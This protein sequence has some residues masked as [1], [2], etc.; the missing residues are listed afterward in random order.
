MSAPR[1]ARP[2]SRSSAITPPTRSVPAH[3]F[4][5]RN[6][7]AYALVF[8]LGAAM[9]A[10]H[11]PGADATARVT[12]LAGAGGCAWEAGRWLHNRARRRA[13]GLR[14]LAD[15]QARARLKTARAERKTEQQDVQQRD[16]QA[17]RQTLQAQ[18]QGRQVIQ[19]A[20]SE[21]EAE[22]R[23]R[24]A[25]RFEA[26]RA[27]A[28]RL[29][30]LP[31]DVWIV[32]LTAIFAGRGLRLQTADIPPPSNASSPSPDNASEDGYYLRFVHVDIEVDTKVD[33]EME[34]MCVARSLPA[35]RAG[36][37]ADVESLEQWRQQT[38]AQ[39]AYLISRDGFSTAVVRLAPRLPLTLVEP[40][41]L[42]QW[43]LTD[44]RS[45]PPAH[46]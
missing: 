34:S 44:A 36:V 16:R 19:Q 31:E 14:E 25:A 5:V 23:A 28:E 21:R 18:K 12:M 4:P 35:G 26:V 7:G 15:A 41:L 10:G 11:R 24:R 9:L 3:P 37:V 8:A 32:E 17:A 13:V 30:A 45:E 42:A 39:Q 29:A 33:I 38:G 6:G 22:E 43:K 20:Q 27:E 1:R 2:D 40:Q 46:S